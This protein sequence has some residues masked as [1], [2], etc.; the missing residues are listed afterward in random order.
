MGIVSYTKG[1]WHYQP[2]DWNGVHD[3]ESPGSIMSE[4]WYI[5]TMEAGIPDYGN[6]E[7]DAV[8]ANARLI[9]AAPELLEAL[10]FCVGVMQSGVVAGPGCDDAKEMQMA[11]DQGAAAIAKAEGR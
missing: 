1:P 7:A 4:D 2:N 8:E 3:N 11:I 5:A 9:A 6:D 10:I